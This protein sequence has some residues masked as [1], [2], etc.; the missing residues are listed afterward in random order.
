MLL[1]AIILQHLRANVVTTSIANPHARSFSFSRDRTTQY[2]LQCAVRYYGWVAL[3]T[4]TASGA[5]R[6][7]R[8]TARLLEQEDLFGLA[9]GAVSFL[10]ASKV[11]R[12][13]SNSLSDS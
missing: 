12:R 1:E 11:S 3:R 13:N 7:K 8:L 5:R 2:K 6:N 9:G 10:Q 4:T